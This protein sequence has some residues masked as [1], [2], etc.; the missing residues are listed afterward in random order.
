MDAS[1]VFKAV[2]AVF[3]AFGL[4]LYHKYGDGAA[5][6]ASGPMAAPPPVPRRVRRARSAPG[7]LA[8]EAAA[9]DGESVVASA[10]PPDARGDGCFLERS[11]DGCL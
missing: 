9:D 3:T 8:K 1:F 5:P 4:W 10:R 11:V 2:V 6:V 7:A